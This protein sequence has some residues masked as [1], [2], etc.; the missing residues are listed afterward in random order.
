MPIAVARTSRYY[1]DMSD[2]L[3]K[4]TSYNIFN[5]LFPGAL[6]VFVSNYLGL[7]SVTESN[8]IVELFIYYFI[9]MT[10]SRFGS[11][12]IEPA[13]KKI[14][15]VNYAPYSDYVSAASADPKIDIL[16][17]VNNTYRTLVALFVLLLLVFA[18]NRLSVYFGASQN[19]VNSVLLV[20]VFLLYVCSY[21]KQTSFIRERVLKNK[22]K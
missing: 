1:L 13:F 9:G 19:I 6:F 5:N 14:G 20:S 17:E 10:I 2:L 3:N 18:G 21:R 12:I 22:A 11:V 15:I 7:F 4:I 16:L 8:V